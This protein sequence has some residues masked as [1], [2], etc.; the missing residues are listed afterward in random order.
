VI[1]LGFEIKGY[2][3]SGR[4][5]ELEDNLSRVSRPDLIQGAF[6][7]DAIVK[8]D[9]VDFSTHFGWVTLLDWCLRLTV[10]I[11]ELADTGSARFSFSESDDFM[12]FRRADEG[13]HV[14]CSYVPEVG[15]IDH[16]EELAIAVRGFVDSKL[17]WISQEFPEAMNNPVMVDVY[18]RIGRPFPSRDDS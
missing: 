2:P 10:A 8:F 4:R 11:R 15:V 1:E 17:A 3:R 18:S 5:V 13:L 6:M 14:T 9:A 12:S 16:Q 7:G